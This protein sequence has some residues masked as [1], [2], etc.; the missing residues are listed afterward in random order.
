MSC[1]ELYVINSCFNIN[2]HVAFHPPK[3]RKS[4]FFSMFWSE[5][6]VF[7]CWSQPFYCLLMKEKVRCKLFFCWC[8]KATLYFAS[9]CAYIATGHN[10]I[11][12]EKLVELPCTIENETI[13][14]LCTQLFAQHYLKL[15]SNW[16]AQRSSDVIIHQS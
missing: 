2:R 13:P 8:K 16:G 1:F 4:L 9:F 12:M 7:C 3:K 14:I 6:G 11:L 15:S 5:T 10:I